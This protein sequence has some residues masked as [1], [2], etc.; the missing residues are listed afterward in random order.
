MASLGQMHFRKTILVFFFP[1]R[2]RYW[3][4]LLLVPNV[5]FFA[6]LLWKLPSARA[7]IHATSSPIFTT[8]Y[9]LVSMFLL[10]VAYIGTLLEHLSE[11]WRNP[12]TS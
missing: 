5:L 12:V 3:D 9:I 1:S 7:K 11:C 10:C 2:V 6:F 4:L 8:F